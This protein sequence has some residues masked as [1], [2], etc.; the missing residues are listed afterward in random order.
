MAFRRKFYAFNYEALLGNFAF[1]LRD[2]HTIHMQSSILFSVSQF[3]KSTPVKNR[4]VTFNAY[5]FPYF[6]KL[7]GETTITIRKGINIYN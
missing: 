4:I 1:T 3:R 6:M 2:V 5:V 7:S